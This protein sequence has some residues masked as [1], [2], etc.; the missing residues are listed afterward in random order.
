MF[1]QFLLTGQRLDNDWTNQRQIARDARS[2]PT[3]ATQEEG[4]QGA[5]C[6][7]NPLQS[8]SANGWRA[9]HATGLD[10]TRG[11]AQRGPLEAIGK[12]YSRVSAQNGAGGMGEVCGRAYT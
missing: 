11:Q 7:Q 9:R 10:K 4:F 2:D 1:G 12:P 5:G 6:V 3:N 8:R